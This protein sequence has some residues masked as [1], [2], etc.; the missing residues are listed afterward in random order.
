MVDEG[1]LEEDVFYMDDNVDDANNC[2]HTSMTGKIPLP[3]SYDTPSPIS[4]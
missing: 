2:E 4:F 3:M 1:N